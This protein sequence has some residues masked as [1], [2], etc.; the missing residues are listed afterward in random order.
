MCPPPEGGRGLPDQV[1]LV[2]GAGRR[3]GRAIAVALGARGMRVVVHY[4]GS[5]EGAD[6]TTRLIEEAG[7]HAIAVQTD[8][9]DPGGPDALIERVLAEYGALDALVNSA[10]IMLRTPVGEVGVAD[11]DTM[12]AINVRAPFFLAQRAAPALARA[13]GSIVNIADLAAFETWP[14]YVPHGMTKA[15]VVQMTRALA[16]ALA[17]DVRVNGVAPGVVML[18]EGWD[19]EEGERLRS[20]TP[21]ARL[22]SAEDVAQAVVYLL[23]AEYVTGDVIRVDGGRHIRC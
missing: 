18:P 4:N 11:W 10:A 8:L 19:P 1:A 20:T 7:G 3:V 15:A 6:E 22:G 14:A 21:L 17:P 12:F 16:H 5:R 23:E 13:R 9:T 2:T